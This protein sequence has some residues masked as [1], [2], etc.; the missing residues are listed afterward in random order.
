MSGNVLEWTRSLLAEYPYDPRDTKREDLAAGD[1]FDRVLRGGSWGIYGRL[2]RCALRDWYLPD[3][4]FNL[5]G[6][7]VVV[8]PS[9]L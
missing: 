6:F 1:N 2:A 3:F 8:L 5:I 4:R 7:R 9:S